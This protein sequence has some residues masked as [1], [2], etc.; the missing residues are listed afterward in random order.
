MVAIGRY[1]GCVAVVLTLVL[2]GA[3]RADHP[4]DGVL[5]YA[6]RNLL[7]VSER[8]SLSAAL[9]DQILNL[10]EQQIKEADKGSVNAT[11]PIEGF[12]IKLGGEGSSETIR[13]YRDE[14]RR[15]TN[16]V[17][18]EEQARFLY[19]SYGNETAIKAWVVCM[20]L[21]SSDIQVWSETPSPNDTRIKFYVNFLPRDGTK[22]GK[23]TVLRAFDGTA[24]ATF[25]LGDVLR[26]DKLQR[27]IVKPNE[28]HA[29]VTLM[30]ACGGFSG[31]SSARIPLPPPPPPPPP[32]PVE[33]AV[34]RE[35]TAIG[36]DLRG[37]DCEMDTNHDD[38][39]TASCSSQL[40]REGSKVVVHVSFE[41]EEGRGP[42]KRGNTKIGGSKRF[43]FAIDPEPG[44][45]FSHIKA[46]GGLSASFSGETHGQ[47]HAFN[48]FHADQ[49]N[50]S[51]WQ[52]LAFRLDAKGRNDCA[53]VGVKGTVKFTCVFV[54]P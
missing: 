19:M 21:Q 5:K 54:A 43:E 34:T 14:Y 36:F 3:A 20:A 23:V 27:V 52:N 29:E 2:T 51:H 35:I 42:V 49:V 8:Q 22:L 41:C 9:R 40:S 15:D 47:N 26:R 4:C 50:R 7:L 6:G 1:Q 32:V 12:P 24:E 31:T 13:T 17:I 45:R 39:A 37:S 46:R 25:A 30:V 11:I 18:N 10:T 33:R 44:M 53:I 16:F 48:P 38:R 28:K